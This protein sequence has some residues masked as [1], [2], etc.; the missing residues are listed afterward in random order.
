[1]TN[2]QNTRPKFR[3]AELDDLDGIVDLLCDLEV[4]AWSAYGIHADGHS[5]VEMAMR[6]IRHGICLVG[7]GAVAGGFVVKFPA[8]QHVLIGNV[9]FWNFTT[10]SGLGVLKAITEE[11]K[12]L[13]AAY[14]SV[15]S[16]FPDNRIGDFYCK[17][18]LQRVETNWLAKIDDMR[19]ST[20]GKTL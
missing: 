5:L 18:G 13:G 15:T 3:K 9:L 16:H 8:N 20:K 14:V 7:D 11:F 17:T 2:L 10:P 12:A 1:M 4:K 19:F 6:S